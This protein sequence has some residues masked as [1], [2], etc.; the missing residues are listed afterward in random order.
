MSLPYAEGQT[1]A[2]NLFGIECVPVFNQQDINRHGLRMMN[3]HTPFASDS[4]SEHIKTFN[5]NA[6]SGMAERLYYLIGEGHAYGEGQIRMVYTPNPDLTAGIWCQTH[7]KAELGSGTPAS[8]FVVGS[9]S[10]SSPGSKPLTYYVTAVQHSVSVDMTDGNIAGE[11][12]L[13]VE[14]ASYGNRIP[15]IALN[16]VSRQS[17]PPPPKDTQRTRRRPKRRRRRR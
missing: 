8:G 7:F 17:P 9:G 15:A 10:S 16:Q 12:I 13:T 3:M 14:R 2:N 5:Q 6:S 1:G 11:T 4:T